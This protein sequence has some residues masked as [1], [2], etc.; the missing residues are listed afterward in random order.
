MASPGSWGAVEGAPQE[1]GAGFVS[2]CGAGAQESGRPADPGVGIDDQQ[3]RRA[4]G[5]VF[6]AGILR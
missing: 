1:T 3:W 4:C 2:A 6:V 5:E